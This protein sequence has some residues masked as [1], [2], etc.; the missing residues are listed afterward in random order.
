MT[1]VT[2]IVPVSS[3]VVANG[4]GH[5]VLT[6]DGGGATVV[7]CHGFLDLAWSWD[8]VARRLSA[9]GYRA[10]AFD[11]RGH[12]ETDHVGA[13]GYYHFPDYCLDLDELLPRLSP[14]PVHLVGHS[15]GGGACLMYAGARG[16]DRLRTVTSIEGLG[17]PAQPGEAAP[18]QLRAWLGTVAASRSRAERPIADLQEALR[19]MRVQSPS[20]PEALG[21]FLAEKNTVRDPDGTLRWRFDRL[22]RTRAPTPFR[23][24]AFE[25]LLRAITVPALFVGCARG[26]RLPDEAERVAWIPRGRRVELP[27]VDHMVHRHAPDTLAEALLA[28]LAEAG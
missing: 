13:G 12:G 9:A 24:E 20:L 8:A 27:G 15:M 17:V 4:L 28:F 5:H 10:V 16:P 7:L 26:F 1:K 23:R 6:W 11:W 22:H 18:D 21:L 14:E 3:R 2:K 25:A 19:R